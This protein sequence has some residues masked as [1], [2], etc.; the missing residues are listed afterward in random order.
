MSCLIS[1]FVCYYSI[2]S[3]YLFLLLEFVPHTSM[4]VSLFI[5]CVFLCVTSSLAAVC[6]PLNC[7]LAYDNL[8]TLKVDLNNY[9]YIYF[10]ICDIWMLLFVLSSCLL[11]YC[12]CLTSSIYIYIY[13]SYTTYS[14]SHTSIDSVDIFYIYVSF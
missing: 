2:S 10:H 4:F 14:L 3:V 7:P 11:T 6:D 8:P 9:S 1:L 12:I 5:I 13:I